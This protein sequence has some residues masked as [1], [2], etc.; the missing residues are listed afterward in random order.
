MSRKEIEDRFSSEV[1]YNELFPDEKSKAEAFDTIARH[2]FFKNFGSTS[3][4]DL[5]LLLY[6]MYLERIYRC[7]G[8]E[9]VSSSDFALSKVLGI[10]QSRVSSLKER[11]EAKYPSNFDLRKEFLPFLKMHI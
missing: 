4:M 5:E 6:S 2:Y 7:E 1:W 11:K 8:S 3:K 9:I 10:T